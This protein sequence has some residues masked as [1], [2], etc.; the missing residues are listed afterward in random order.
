M[1]YTIV[2]IAG[3]K[4]RGQEETSVSQVAFALDR[5]FRKHPSTIVEKSV[6]SANLPNHTPTKIIDA[7]EGEERCEKTN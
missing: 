5:A 1:K 3:L 6:I 7:S 4:T 2:M